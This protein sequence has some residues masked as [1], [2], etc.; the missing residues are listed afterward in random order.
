MADKKVDVAVVQPQDVYG[1]RSRVSWPAILAGAVLSLAFFFLLTL[2]A[3]TAGLSLPSDVKKENVLSIA[4][5]Y[6]LVS[7]VASLFAGGYAASMLTAGE[8][9][10]EGV[11]YGVLVWASTISLLMLLGAAGAKAG[12]NGIVSLAT[13]GKIADDKG[14]FTQEK[15]DKS[16]LDA[17]YSQQ[18]VDAMKASVKSVPEKI[19]NA[20]NDPKTQEEIKEGAS[21]VGLFAFLGVLLSLV[22]AAFG[23]LYGAG[24]KVFSVDVGASGT[25]KKR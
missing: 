2:V 18:D 25:V 22:S 14:A 24:V 5:I 15:I 9:K 3:A 4:G 6:A 11:V 7:I 17:G 20:A 10:N 23:G 1:V 21:Y 16:L 8:S 19:R 12:F 13:A